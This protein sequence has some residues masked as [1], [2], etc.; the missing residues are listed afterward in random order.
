MC[1]VQHTSDTA[2]RR[3]A[4]TLE[5]R[6]SKAKSTK[7]NRI[8]SVSTSAPQKPAVK[9]AP[10]IDEEALRL[11]ALRQKQMEEEREAQERNDIVLKNKAKNRGAGI[12]R[13]FNKPKDEGET[14]SVA[15]LS[16]E[17]EERERNRILRSVSG[18]SAELLL[19]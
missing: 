19:S 14:A 9:T 16:G 5:A 10:V 3:I 11:A 17:E 8:S 7:L 13:F 15:G 18:M 6:M 1:A 2:E 12:D 4:Q